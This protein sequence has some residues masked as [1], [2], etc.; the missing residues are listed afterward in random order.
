MDQIEFGNDIVQNTV[1]IIIII[2]Q[3]QTVKIKY[4]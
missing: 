1:R 2:N 3:L 4:I